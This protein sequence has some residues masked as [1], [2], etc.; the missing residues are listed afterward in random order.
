MTKIQDA[1]NLTV[2]NLFCQETS[3]IYDSLSS[4]DSEHRFDHLPYPEEI[5]RQIPNPGGWG[6]GMEDC[7][8]NAGTMLDVCVRKAELEPENRIE[9]LSFAEKLLNGMETCALI[10]GVPGFVVRGISPRDGRSCYINSSRDQFTLF[11]YG[12]WRYSHCRNIT[13]NIRRKISN[14]LCHVADYCERVVT[15]ENNYD[16]LRLDGMPALVSKMYQTDPH[17]AYR[18]PMI[19]LAAWDATGDEKYRNLYEQYADRAIAKTELCMDKKS[20]FSWAFVQLQA[21][22]RL[23]VEAD[24]ESDR[25]EKM[26]AIME[27]LADSA[28]TCFD[29]AEKNILSFD[30]IWDK[31]AESWSN[32]FSMSIRQETR[33]PGKPAFFYGYLYLFPKEHEVYMR[34][35]ETLRSLGNFAAGI[36]L[37]PASGRKKLLSRFLECLEK[38]DFKHQTSCGSC[39]I[40]HG[41]Y[42]TVAAMRYQPECLCPD[43]L[44]TYRSASQ[45]KRI[46][47]SHEHKCFSVTQEDC[48]QMT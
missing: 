18:L 32:S 45:E 35:F 42:S 26:K 2:Q 4:Q 47:V 21:S 22:L 33:R 48:K 16:L 12:L 40:L 27:R 5:R 41:Y 44:K 7:M 20:W 28:S 38:V 10:H 43:R 36:G 37:A 17:E 3:L 15:P 8:L 13:E 1:W 34:A 9:A 25:R 11:V 14:I 30:G 39:N 46:P 24:P 19:Y 6:T 29:C 31:S 23:G